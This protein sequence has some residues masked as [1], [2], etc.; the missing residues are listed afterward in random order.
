[1]NWALCMR[2]RVVDYWTDGG[3]GVKEAAEQALL[4][5]D[6]DLETFLRGRRGGRVFYR[7]TSDGMQIVAKA[8]KNNEPNVIQ[9]LLATYGK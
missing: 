2:E 5:K 6:E 7:N 4:G 9:R 1:M 3:P 8:D